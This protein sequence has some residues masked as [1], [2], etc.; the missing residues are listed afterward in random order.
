MS[1]PLRPMLQTTGYGRDNDMTQ[2]DLQQDGV[3]AHPHWDGGE[4]DE[5][6]EPHH[7]PATH[8]QEPY[9][10]MGGTARL[11]SAT[12][13][14]DNDVCLTRRDQSSTGRNHNRPH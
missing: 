2:L 9:E 1:L 8:H 10:H 11:C 14:G 3:R 12:N 5:E 4:Q 6:L 13:V 7:P